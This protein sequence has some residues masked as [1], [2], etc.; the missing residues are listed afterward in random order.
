MRILGNILW[1]ILGGLL[2]ALLYIVGGLLLCLTIIGIPFGVQAFKLAGLS[3][4][5][6]GTQVVY[7]EK[8]T[9][10]VSVGMNI[11][12]ILVGGF[13]IAVVHLV[14]AVICGITIV[15]IPFA[16]QH[17]KLMALAFA[18]FGVELRD[19]DSNPNPFANPNRP[20]ID[21]SQQS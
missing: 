6:F 15:L 13:W 14:F 11:L 7:G 10:C 1:F 19:Y 18:P 16:Q 5:P 9:G 3:L 20:M 12:W 21:R 8:V 2:A 17:L 4:T